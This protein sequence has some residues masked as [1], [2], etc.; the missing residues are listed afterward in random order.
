MVKGGSRAGGKGKRLLQ[1]TTEEE[2][3]IGAKVEEV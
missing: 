1:T 2:N 3:A